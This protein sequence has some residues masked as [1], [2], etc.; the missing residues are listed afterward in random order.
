[1]V[2][3]CSCSCVFNVAFLYAF[4]ACSLLCISDAY[5][6]FVA[7]GLCAN[8]MAFNCCLSV[9]LVSY[10]CLCLNHTFLYVC[11]CL[12]HTAFCVCLSLNHTAF[13]VCLFV[14]Y[15]VFYVCLRVNHIIFYHWLCGSLAKLLH[16]TFTSIPASL[17]AHNSTPPSTIERFLFQPINNIPTI[18]KK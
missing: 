11:L 14:N 8:C 3:V 6:K 16:A 5:V 10:V 4:L 17:L 2:S 13:C 1:M 9:N 15:A 12:N 18:N 7:H